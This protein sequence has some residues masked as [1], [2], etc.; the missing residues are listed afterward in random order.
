MIEITPNTETKCDVPG[1]HRMATH[2]SDG[3]EVDRST[4]RVRATDPDGFEYVKEVPLARPAVKGLFFCGNADHQQ[5]AHSE[6]AKTFTDPRAWREQFGEAVTK[7]HVPP[8]DYHK[9]AV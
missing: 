5:W 8:S 1:C 6:D 2:K 9:R 7:G 3:T 4:K